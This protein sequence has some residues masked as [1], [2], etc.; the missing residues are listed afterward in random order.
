MHSSC[1]TKGEFLESLVYLFNIRHPEIS[2]RYDFDII[3]FCYKF[4]IEKD[5]CW[6]H[7]SIQHDKLLELS[8][9]QINDMFDNMLVNLN[10]IIEEKNNDKN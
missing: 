4:V 3:N 5:D 10:K 6:Y 7:M 1:L 8:A 2:L 9:I